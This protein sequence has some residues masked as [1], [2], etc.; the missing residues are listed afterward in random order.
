MD[1]IAEP[2]MV[3]VTDPATAL[4][5]RRRGLP[6]GYEDW[7]NDRS[8]HRRT[9]SALLRLGLWCGAAA[10]VLCS[11]VAFALVFIGWDR[12]KVS[13]GEQPAA[14][15]VDLVP[16]PASVETAPAQQPIDSTV[17]DSTAKL[18]LEPP[19]VATFGLS[20]NPSSD[21]AGSVAAPALAIVAS[22]A[23][24]SAA[25]PVPQPRKR[26]TPTA[27][28]AAHA[29]R[30]QRRPV[31][32]PSREIAHATDMSA[33]SA[34][35]ATFGAGLTPSELP[36]TWKSRLLAHLDRHKR[37]PANAGGVSGISLLSFTMDR[38]GRVLGFFIARSSGS[39]P[40]D[41]ETLAM[42]QRAAPLPAVPN[43]IPG[44]PLQF[45]V[46]VRFSVR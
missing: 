45:T 11:H 38:Q 43:E 16:L 10:F 30:S 13:A 1:E 23:P 12:P 14:V 31:P 15:M 46:P 18:L 35:S 22:P 8:E 34:P 39:T 20:S 19:V 9:S 33:N 27:K 26:T 25:P 44:E 40:L 36:S 17:R 4:D 42:I 7:V 21:P 32:A 6:D 3:A 2:G 37:Y 41:E 28:P 5:W 24:N 29:E